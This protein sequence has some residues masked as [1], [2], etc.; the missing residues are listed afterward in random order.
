MDKAPET[1]TPINRGWQVFHDGEDHIIL[2]HPDSKPIALIR[3]G[4]TW[5]VQYIEFKTMAP[6]SED[7]VGKQFRRKM[8]GLG[9]PS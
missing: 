8:M 3:R 6:Y 7:Y 2:A 4:L 9:E 5:D 1:P